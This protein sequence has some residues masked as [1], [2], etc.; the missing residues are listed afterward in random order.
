MKRV[1]AYAFKSPMTLPE[2][3]ARL[4]EAGPWRWIERESDRFGDYISARA[5][6]DP[7]HGMVK[8]FIEGDR[9]AVDLVLDAEPQK[10]DAVYDTL[11]A[12][13]L[14]RIDASEITETEHYE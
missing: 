13:L 9:F 5:L 6:A 1:R 4:D 10:L 8:I 7:D 12:H 14:P 11:F 3:R 2:I